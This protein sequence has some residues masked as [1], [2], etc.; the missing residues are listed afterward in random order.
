MCPDRQILSV[1]LDGELPSPWKEKVESHLEVCPACRDLLESYR[2]ASASG[3]GAD[4]R[5][6]SRM[7]AA[8]ERVWRNIE[9]RLERAVPLV[10]PER[11][12]SLWRRSIAV[13]LPAV[14]AAALIFIVLAMFW[15]KRPAEPS[16]MPNMILA[17]EEELGPAGMA[18][19]SDMNGVLQYLSGADSGDILILRLPESRNFTSSGEPA[20]IRAAD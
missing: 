11:R 18:P 6:R 14:A 3:D 13:P 20:I 7:E 17:S 15:L 8:G 2:L 10:F 9:N 19:V 16:A 4:A 1:Y 5:E 12:I